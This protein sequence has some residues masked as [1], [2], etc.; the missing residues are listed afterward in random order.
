M[1]PE[2]AGVCALQQ[3]G[4]SWYAH[5]APSSRRCTHIEL[6]KVRA[7]S[8]KGLVPLSDLD[9]VSIERPDDACAI[10]VFRGEHDL[11]SRDAVRDLLSSLVEEREL[12]VADFSDARFVDS[13]MLSALMDVR[14]VAQERGS[15]FRLQLST[16]SIVRRAFEISG[17]AKALGYASTREEAFGES[18]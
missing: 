18:H 10:V 12:V 6:R 11:A 8:R 7:L 15:A 4:L 9:D 2:R 3:W 17:V 16:A 13:S 5:I 1:V 14:K